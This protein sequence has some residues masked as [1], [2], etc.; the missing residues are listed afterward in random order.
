VI[1]LVHRRGIHLPSLDL[2]LDPSGRRD[3][4]F[5]SHAH[6]D[7]AGRH[8]QTILSAPT[9]QLMRARLGPSPCEHVFEFG[10]SREMRGARLTLLPAG[11]VLGSAQLHVESDTGSLLYTG[12]FKLRPGPSCEP[13]AWRPADT[14]VME[15]TFGRPEFVFP[16]TEV[17]CAD[18]VRFCREALADGAV[19]VLLAY[20]L[21]KAQEVLCAV[22]AAGLSPMLHGAAAKMTRIYRGFLPD[23]PAFADYEAGNVGGHVLIFPPNVRASDAMQRIRN[24]RVGMVTGWALSSGAVHRYRCDAV[25]PL[26]DHA[27]YDDLLRYVELV[28]P[29]RVLTL[30]GY[31]ADFARDLRARGIEAWSLVS[32]DQLEFPFAP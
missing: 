20:S 10:L 25:F 16:P 1:E 2:W 17:V 4:A 31:A 21:G 28:A 19:P 23:L 9:A 7:H 5:V 11:H 8:G 12:D 22:A 27:G 30:H 26:S 29:R 3:F 15:T 32:P 6:S 14:L 24:R 18:M 13:L